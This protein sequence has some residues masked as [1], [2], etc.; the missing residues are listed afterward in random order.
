MEKDIKTKIELVREKMNNIERFFKEKHI[1]HYGE[2]IKLQIEDKMKKDRQELIVSLM[3][4]D[5]NDDYQKEL[6][7][8]KLDI[9]DIF[10][11]C[12]SKLGLSLYEQISTINT[13]CL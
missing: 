12:I 3:N 9:F 11:D 6:L 2:I 8:D 1:P 5:E 13:R 4:Y 10:Y 7:N